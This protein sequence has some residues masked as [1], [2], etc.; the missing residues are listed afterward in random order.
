MVY[1]LNFFMDVLSGILS[2]LIVVFL[3]IAIY[4]SAGRGVIGGYSIEEMVPY[5]LGGGLI[6]SFILTTAEN[7]ETSQ[8]I[9]DGNL[10]F[11][12]IKPLSPYGVWMARD[13]GSKAFLLSLGL[14]GYLFVFLFS[15]II[16][17]PLRAWRIS[18]FF[19]FRSYWQ[20]CF[21]FFSLK[22]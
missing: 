16:C 8:S 10:S 7:S 17:C 5:I 12:L 11:L 22:V 3:W 13:L 2:S 4:K 19:F 1:R 15:G 9:Q 20:P 18:F 6:N 21:N 14:V